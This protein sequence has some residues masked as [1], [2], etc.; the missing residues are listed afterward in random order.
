[1]ARPTSGAGVEVTPAL[2]DSIRD[3]LRQTI[4]R[5]GAL[6]DRLGGGSR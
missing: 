6:L 1:M 4:E 5:L 2:V 3:E